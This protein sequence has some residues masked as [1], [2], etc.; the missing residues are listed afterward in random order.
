M[1]GIGSWLGFRYVPN[2]STVTTV[3][4]PQLTANIEEVFAELEKILVA[5]GLYQKEATAMIKTWKDSWF[6]EGLRVFYILLRMTTD[7]ILPLHVETKPKQTVRIL[8]GRTE[9]ITPEME[10]DVRKQVALLNSKSSYVR[11]NAKENLQKHGRFYE[12]IL[13]STLNNETNASLRKQIKKLIS[14]QV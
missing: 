4:R 7:E 1:S 3:E 11:A 6:E 12:P 9:L 14:Q 8:V 10:N 5:Q 13:K 2:L